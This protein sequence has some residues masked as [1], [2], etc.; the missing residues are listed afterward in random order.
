M[1]DYREAMKADITAYI[2][3]DCDIDEWR[4]DRDGFEE[5]LNDVLWCTDRVTGNASGSY[6]FDRNEAFKCLTEG[7][8]FEIVAQAISDWCIDA[9]TIADK[10]SELD[11]EWF[12]VTAR[13][14]LLSEVISTVLDELYASDEMKGG[15]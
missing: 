3:D 6:T 7:N 12:D 10:L 8:G 11:W 1:Y 14:F 13:C 15:E 4:G 5:H 9:R 2:E